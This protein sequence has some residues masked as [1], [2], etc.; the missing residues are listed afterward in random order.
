MVYKRSIAPSLRFNTR[1]RAAGEDLL[2]F[3]MLASTAGRVAFI[4]DSLV[5]CGNGVNMY[6][7]NFNW[8][9]PKCVER[10]SV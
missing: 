9:S 1:L 10:S 2:F 4:R 6:F 5:E 7:G 8:D 3:A